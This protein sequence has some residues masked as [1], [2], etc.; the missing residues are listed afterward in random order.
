M[1]FDYKSYTLAIKSFFIKSFFSFF[2]VLY[3]QRTGASFLFIFSFSLLLFSFF[4]FLFLLGLYFLQPK[5]ALVS[6]WFSSCY[7]CYDVV[8]ELLWLP[9]AKSRESGGKRMPAFVSQ[10]GLV[11]QSLTAEWS[12]R[13]LSWLTFPLSA[14]SHTVHLHRPCTC[15]DRSSVRTTSVTTR[16]VSY[17]LATCLDWLVCLFGRSVGRSDWLGSH[18]WFITITTFHYP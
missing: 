9:V 1:I 17:L 6:P 8:I 2:P 13:K 18:H 14:L 16:R 7:C 10:V 12:R 15:T 4:Q 3:K 11:H 5:L